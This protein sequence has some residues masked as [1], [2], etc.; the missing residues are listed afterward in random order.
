MKL[1]AKKLLTAFC[2]LFLSVFLFAGCNLIEVNKAKYY[3]QIVVSVELKDGIGKEYEFYKK[4]YS[5]KDLL[6]AYNTYAYSY[7]SSGQ[8]DAETGVEYAINQMVGTDLLYKYIKNNYFDNP[9]YDIVFTDADKNEVMLKV[10][11]AIQG[12][13]DEYEE[14]IYEEWEYD[15]TKQGDLSDEEKESLRA[16][17]EDYTSKL[18]IVTMTITENGKTKD[19]TKIVL[20][21]S[22]INKVY[23]NRVAGDKF[24][25]QVGD[26]EVSKEAYKRYISDLQEGARAEG[27][28]TDENT[29]LAE[30]IK[31]LKEEYT[32]R[33]YFSLFET[34]YNIHSR[35]TYNAENDL[36]ILNEDVEEEVLAQYKEKYLKQR[37]LYQ[38]NEAKYH[39][40][41]AG[42]STDD[43]Y[44]HYNSGNEYM[45]VSHILLKFSDKQQADIKELKARLDA[46]DITQESYDRKVQDIANKT[47]VTYEING[48][49]YVE[50]ASKVVEDIT[51]YVNAVVVGDKTGDE[52][53]IALNERAKRFNDMLYIY[54]DDEGIMNK[55]FPYVVNLDTE[56]EDKMVKEFA[57]T[58]RELD[59]NGGE[60]MMSGMVI[61]EYGV[62]ILYHAGRVE[63]VVDDM[64]ALTALDLMQKHTQRSSNKT[65]F[66]NI[67]DSISNDLY[68]TATQG[69]VANC[70]NLVKVVKY[71]KRYSDL[72]K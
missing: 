1:T 62:H 8:L 36:Y 26:K 40:A 19:V 37:N 20:S 45:Y 39:E 5:K 44:Y 70:Y 55:D 43:I 54:N 66:T 13:I 69:F 18:R 49:K 71:D 72:L 4:Q 58:A 3:N 7:V 6:V 23:S 59:Q 29:V 28:S 46:G 30:E 2:A 34:W 65:L 50:S 25:Q 42:D 14:E 52:R 67:Y 24:V 17:Y 21:P 63:T 51:T 60:G 15:Y 9:N 22:E 57:N 10:Y 68:N 27:K 12:Q 61:T 16:E 35:F 31:R 53:E 38:N 47:V 64:D 56:V 48:T 33:E 32:R 11:D 41:M